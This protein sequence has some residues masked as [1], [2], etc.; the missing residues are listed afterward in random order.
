MSVFSFPD[1]INEYAARTVAT[2]VASSLVVAFV[3]RWS[4]VFP[5]LGAG[6]LLR[7]GWGPKISPL[8]RFAMA[9]AGRFLGTK[10]VS[11]APKRFA[12]GIG[13]VC[14]IAATTLWLLQLDTAAWIVAAM[15]VVFATLEASVAFCMGCWVYARLQYAGVFPPEVCTDCAPRPT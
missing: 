14:M 9:F 13:A 6:F 2:V 7:V 15:V 4:W 11:G 10:P 5:I 1:R 8:A 3:F 12:Q